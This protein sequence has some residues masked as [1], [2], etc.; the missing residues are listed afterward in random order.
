MK[1][2]ECADN[3]WGGKLYIVAENIHDAIELFEKK[4]GYLPQMVFQTGEDN[5]IVQ[6]IRS[7]EN[8]RS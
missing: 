8:E 7:K 6:D 2:F 5:V 1:L 3:D 4:T